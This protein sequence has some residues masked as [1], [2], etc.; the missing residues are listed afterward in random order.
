LGLRPDLPGDLK[1]PIIIELSVGFGL[2]AHKL[3]PAQVEEQFISKGLGRLARL[4]DHYNVKPS[5]PDKGR[6]LSWHLASELGL[7]NVA[8]EGSKG[9]GR[10]RSWSFDEQL[11]LMKE[12]D[13]IET[14][15]GRGTADAIH[16]LK[17]RLPKKSPSKFR[18]ISEKSL[19][20]RY[21]EAKKRTA[22]LFGLAL[23]GRPEPLPKK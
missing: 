23:A 1:K 21:G 17:A 19:A 7:M 2:S 12:I 9:R 18:N 4:L 22:N 8:T 16:I 3:T 5:N 20:N 14:E 11:A 15:R 10:P 6:L 13:A